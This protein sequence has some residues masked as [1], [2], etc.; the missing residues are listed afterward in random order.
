[1]KL[2]LGKL[3]LLNVRDKWPDEARNFTPWL[4]EEESMAELGSA[5]GIELELENTEVSVGPYSADI[6]AKDAGTGRYVV[7][8]NQLEKTN[9]DHLGKAIT[10]ASVLEASAVIWIAS[11]F[12][13]EHKKALDWLNDHTDDE[14]SFYG[15]RIELWQIDDSRPALRFNL[16][17]W[18]ADIRQAAVRRASENLTEVKK[19]QLDFWT[20]FRKRL[21]DCKEM[22]SPGQSPRPQYWYDVPL[23]KS[24]IVISNTCNTYDKRLGVRV[25]ISNRIADQALPQLLDRKQEI[26]SEIGEQLV[27]DPHPNNRDKVIVV[28]L[29]ADIDD[30]EKWDEYLDWMRDT[31]LKFRRTFSKRV[32]QLDLEKKFEQSEDHKES[33]SE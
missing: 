11:D 19:L 27:W 25:Y 10:Y 24:G 13:E 29:D 17:S 22:P 21:T 6:L 9:H 3:R 26:E 33:I 2:D 15:V 32:K 4:A 14:V 23:G 18:P 31:T 28:Y 7:I 30:R 1:M 5:L 12:T 8:E 20:E 16:M